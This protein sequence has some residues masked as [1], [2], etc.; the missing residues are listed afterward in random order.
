MADCATK[1]DQCHPRKIFVGGLGHKLSTQGLRDHFSKYG[2]IVDAVVL[3]W[4]DGRSRGF[5]YVT[6]AD[7]AAASAAI[8][9]SHEIGGREV[10]VK[11]AVPGTNKLFVGGLPQN[12]TAIELRN[13]FENLG[14]VSDAVVMIDPTTNRSRGFGFICFLPGPEGTAAVDLALAQYDC[15]RIRGKWVEVKSAAPPH[16]L[17]GKDEHQSDEVRA[18]AAAA[19]SGPAVRGEAARMGVTA[20]H[21]STAAPS[22]MPVLLPAREQPCLGEAEKLL[23]ASP[24]ASTYAASTYTGTPT[25]YTGTPTPPG[26][27]VAMGA[28]TPQWP[29]MVLPLQRGGA[30]PPASLSL[31]EAM[32]AWM[33]PMQAQGGGALPSLLASGGG[34]SPCKLTSPMKVR[35]RPQST[36]PEA[37]WDTHGLSDAGK[38]IQR[39]LEELR[40]FSAASS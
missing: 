13:Y 10:D 2:T 24:Y 30:W 4:P 3:R 29:P 36:W 23:A 16:K 31:D 25:P 35:V 12:V 17:M 33:R 15:H 19:A 11:R 6:F 8:R 20:T 5:G 26:L 18:L 38:E 40:Y 32:P 1:D 27:Q 21:L 37:N 34:C 39:S 9:E 7:L 28:R 22:T 14:S